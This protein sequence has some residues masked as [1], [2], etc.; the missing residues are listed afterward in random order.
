MAAEQE[1]VLYEAFPRGLCAGVVKAVD[2]SEA[3]IANVRAANPDATIYYVGTPA[4]NTH[5]IDR[6]RNNGTK[7]I[8]HISEA[9]AG[10][11]A[12]FGPH[13]STDEDLAMAREKKITFVDTECPLVTKVKEEI[14]E[15][16][17]RGVPTLYHGK[18]GHPETRAA[19]S[20]GDVILFETGEEAEKI[21]RSLKDSDPELKLGYAGQTTHNADESSK[22]AEKIRDIV[23]DL[24]LPRTSDQCF[25]TRDRQQSLRDTL[26]RGVEVQ[27]VVGSPSSS[28]S[29]ELRDIAKE[30][31]PN[32][33]FVD[34]ADELPIEDLKGFTRYG[35]TAGASVEEDVIDNV[36]QKIVEAASIQAIEHV[37]SADESKMKFKHAPVQKPPYDR[38]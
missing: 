17:A 34:S 38:G 30:K 37:V 36:R 33:F 10:G 25:A 22:I 19:I 1:S 15:R 3:F 12:I 6:F 7:F 18:G 20:A 24:E 9:E 31:T 28:N 11:Y 2:E 27:I 35:L 13:G 29:K 16:T 4:H 32:V 26:A 8:D 14:R 21:A 5:I 23:P